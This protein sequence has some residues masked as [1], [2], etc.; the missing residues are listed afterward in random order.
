MTPVTSERET[1][2][3][4]IDK[5]LAVGDKQL[6]HEPVGVVLIYKNQAFLKAIWTKDSSREDN[7]QALMDAALD[8][9]SK[10]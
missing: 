9:A 7:M 4:T 3:S 10:S 8:E 1:T 5:M 2:L 6:G